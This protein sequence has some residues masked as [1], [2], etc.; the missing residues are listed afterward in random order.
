[1]KINIY[2]KIEVWMF[3]LQCFRF[4]YNYCYVCIYVSYNINSLLSVVSAMC[5]IA[6]MVYVH[7]IINVPKSVIFQKCVCTW[8]YSFWLQLCILFVYKI[9]ALFI[10]FIP[11]KFTFYILLFYYLIVLIFD[12]STIWLFYYF[13]SLFFSLCLC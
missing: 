5:I 1:M 8:L 2:R 13:Y 11:L 6:F 10:Q 7:Y 3:H 4:I 12:C 9:S